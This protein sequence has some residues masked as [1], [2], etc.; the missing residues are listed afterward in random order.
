MES[1]A[2]VQTCEVFIFKKGYQNKMDRVKQLKH[3]TGRMHFVDSTEW[4][5]YLGN[6]TVA[7][8]IMLKVKA[9]HPRAVTEHFEITTPRNP[10]VR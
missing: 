7:Y 10:S 9:W 8:I 1:M 2:F 4:N 5:V 3:K 6:H